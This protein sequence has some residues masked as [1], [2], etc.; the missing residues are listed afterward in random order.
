MADRSEPTSPLA[1]GGRTAALPSRAGSSVREGAWRDR[2]LIA[3]FFLSGLSGL[4]YEVV[5]LRMLI[6]AFGV[7][8]YA[9]TTVLVVFMAG[10]ALGSIGVGRYLARRASR[11]GTHAGSM[12]LRYYAIAEVL[13]GV[14]ALCST[15]VIIRLPAIFQ[16]IVVTVGGAPAFI[17]LLR[18]GLA[19][20]VLLLPTVLMGATLPLLSGHL[21]STGGRAGERAGTLYGANTIG[22]VLG[23][24]GAGFFLLFLV[25]EE[26]TALIAAAI[27][28]GVGILAFGLAARA[29]MPT[30]PAPAPITDELD[31]RA[32]GD[33]HAS[34][35]SGAGV[36]RKIVLAYAVSGFSALAYQVIW[37]RMLN[38]LLGNS[39]YGFSSM[40]GAYLIGLGG[41]SLVMARYTSRIARPIAIFG[42][43]ETAIA[44]LA[45][46]SLHVFTALGLAERSTDYT[47]SQIWGLDDFARLAVAAALVV[48]PVTIAL[49][50]IF[51]IACRLAHHPSEPAEI[52]IG[53]LYGYNTV[54][55]IV[56]S[57]ASGFV[58]VPL[59][60]TTLSFLLVSIATFLIGIYLLRLSAQTGEIVRPSVVMLSLGLALVVVL[61]VSMRDPL[62]TVLQARLNP[63]EHVIAHQEGGAATVTATED[64]RQKHLFV[65]GLYVSTTDRLTG[66]L[67][68]HL[69][70]SFQ[71]APA[72]VLVIGL[73]VG[74]A[75]KSALEHGV[76][77]T[78]VDLVPNVVDLFKLF[79]P[80]YQSY[81]E[82]PRGRIV[83]NDGRNFLLST[84]EKFD[85]VLVDGTP[86][87]FA[88]G[89]VNLYSLEFVK[90]V[91][92][93]LTS[94]GVFALYFPTTCFESDFWMIARNFADTFQRM[95]FWTSQGVSG[96]LL[97][98]TPT[99]EPIFATPAATLSDRLHRVKNV[100]PHFT[101][102]YIQDGLFPDE[103]A[104]RRKAAVYP[105]LTDDHP[106]TEFPLQNFWRGEKYVRSN[107][108]LRSF[109]PIPL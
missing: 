64:P 105:N 61:S 83:I 8:I 36:E 90:M 43:L 50:A 13:I 54:G 28:L 44:F 59:L 96:I 70:L 82:D 95:T 9:V 30:A 39:V 23:V 53:R 22:A 45:L 66:N 85:L 99:A 80:E 6:R 32:S 34:A 16:A 52:S 78:V 60:G 7:T 109:H 48:L 41:G 71:P 37:S 12:L 20:L 88:S 15:E 91:K 75:F 104:A 10:L 38:L 68:I 51:P 101:V 79:Q 87:V 3:L 69:P 35:A 74:E 67:M 27:N 94:T 98:G 58:L 93:H 14:T 21:T 100:D 62:L 108:F 103:Q 86:P 2:A 46:L 84:A 107:E 29:V 11:R 26:R 55:A 89:M 92:E 76:S 18:F 81:L 57:F 77:V 42:F 33:L 65:N 56:G 47:Y 49:G 73:G 4:I 106:Y 31:P 17:A 24:I 19:V 102:A 40:L 63:D 72:K 97:L 25:G 5:W 1:A